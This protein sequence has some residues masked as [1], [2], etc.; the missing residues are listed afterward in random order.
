MI[1]RERGLAFWPEHDIPETVSAKRQDE[2]NCRLSCIDANESDVDLKVLDNES[3]AIA[4][5][6]L[7]VRKLLTLQLKERIK[8]LKKTP[9]QFEQYG[10]ALKT[11]I[12]ADALKENFMEIVLNESM[13]WDQ[14]IPR[15]KESF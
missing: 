3:E 8:V 7:G 1:S 15:T 10:L 13:N 6:K 5:H 11:Y 12:E 2:N 9:P 4:L 14:P